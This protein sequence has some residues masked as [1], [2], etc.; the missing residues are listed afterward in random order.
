MV[1]VGQDYWFI[2]RDNQ[3]HDEQSVWSPAEPGDQG[4][5]PV[6]Q[7][8]SESAVEQVVEEIL[9]TRATLR[10]MLAEVVRAMT[11]SPVACPSGGFG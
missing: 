2:A 4:V 11:R 5:W 8:S 3:A 6:L 7:K 10:S 1:G 9:A